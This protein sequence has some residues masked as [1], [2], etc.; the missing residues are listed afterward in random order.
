MPECKLPS[1]ISE[2]MR[3]VRGLDL[4]VRRRRMRREPLDRREPSASIRASGLVARRG[5]TT[6]GPRHRKRKVTEWNPSELRL[7]CCSLAGVIGD[8]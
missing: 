1:L 6:V 7:R 2:Y 3:S 8:R 4:E 5:E